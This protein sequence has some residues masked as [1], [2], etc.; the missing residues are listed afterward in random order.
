MSEQA[1]CAGDCNRSSKPS[2]ARRPSPVL[3]EPR[4]KMRASGRWSVWSFLVVTLGV[5]L[6]A[7]CDDAG[8]TGDCVP[9]SI[10]SEFV[11][12]ADSLSVQLKEAKASLEAAK[13]EATD[14][15]QDLEQKLE[16]ALK[17]K[18][19]CH[20]GT[21]SL[22]KKIEKCEGDVKAMSASATK[23]E[24][25]M[26]ECK[27]KVSAM[28]EQSSE[29]LASCHREVSE[30]RSVETGLATCEADLKTSAT[31]LATTKSALQSKERS[32]VED[33]GNL[34]SLLEKGEAQRKE[35]VAASEA[36]A[37]KLQKLQKDLTR[38][39]SLLKDAADNKL[40]FSMDQFK[41]AARKVILVN[42]ALGDLVYR[43]TVRFIPAS[44]FDE[45]QRLRQ[46][47]TVQAA[48]LYQKVQP[49]VEKTRQIV[50]D[51]AATARKLYAEFVGPHVDVAR[52]QAARQ[53]S[54]YV[55][56]AKTKGTQSLDT[57]NKWVDAK[58]VAP[59]ATSQPNVSELIPASTSDRVAAFV[60]LVFVLYLASLI[61]RLACRKALWP[62][63]RGIVSVLLL[64]ITT[65]RWLFRRR[66][67][68]A[69]KAKS[70][71]SKKPISTEKR[72]FKPA[73]PEDVSD[74]TKQ[75]TKLGTSPSKKPDAAAAKKH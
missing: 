48:A 25:A 65:L 55:A 59:L 15:Q 20:E 71:T 17:Q 50:S 62:T 33:L 11:K 66:R 2:Y 47:A 1:C 69:K 75:K 22:F 6:V 21:E 46:Q 70:S 27:K 3:F 54:E 18:Q 45:A 52:A 53:L 26:Q 16:A 29:A 67:S 9:E 51:H 56:I 58:V 23:Q 35:A 42:R 32:F 37:K 63:L 4:A 39:E 14:V 38:A 13:K 8:A 74:K 36:Q 40:L 30:L 44:T 61:V 57:I 60:Y 12:M 41:D 19:T 73:T 28:S 7:Q 24:T 43:N 49:H 68:P 10:H 64:P 34:R 5:L 72:Q 31:A